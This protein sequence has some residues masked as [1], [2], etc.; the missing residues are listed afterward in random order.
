MVRAMARVV[1]T[2]RAMIELHAS[3]EPER[4]LDEIQIAIRRSAFR[5]VV[6]CVGRPNFNM[7]SNVDC[8]L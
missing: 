5:F 7:A 1:T 4:S 2:R 3:D 8:T 6:S